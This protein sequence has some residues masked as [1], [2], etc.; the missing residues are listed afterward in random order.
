MKIAK[1]IF[2]KNPTIVAMEWKKKLGGEL[3]LA[4]KKKKWTLEQLR[5]ELDRA[6]FKISLNTLGHYERGE[7]APDFDDL[8]RMAAVLSTPR[9]EIAEDL[10]IEFS[11]NGHHPVPSPQQLTLNFDPD[12]GVTIRIQ[13]TGTQVTIKKASA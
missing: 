12:G 6:N 10:R 4:R 8:R 9:F 11:P 5:D 13:P 1:S 7:R 3:R 2:I